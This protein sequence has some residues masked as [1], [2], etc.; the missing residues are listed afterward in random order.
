MSILPLT[1]W[2][3]LLIF[4]QATVF[5]HIHLLGYATPLPY[6]YFLMKLP[7]D[8]SRVTYIVCGFCLGLAIDVFSNTPGMTAASLCAMG[9]I[10]PVLLKFFLPA[11]H[12]EENFSPS[13]HSMGK[14]AFL[15]FTLTLSI[16][17]CCLFFTI[18]SFSFLDWQ[19]LLCKIGSSALLTF[20]CV[21]GLET[22]STPHKH[23]VE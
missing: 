1:G 11:D 6:L 5:N 2:L 8:S 20:I 15:L 22:V 7:V 9:L 12:E 4:L 18:E 3:F 14:S 13:M 17:H 19:T 16:L 21:A 10:T 23:R